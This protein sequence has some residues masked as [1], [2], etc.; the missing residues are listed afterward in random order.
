MPRLEASFRA[1]GLLVLIATYNNASTLKEVIEETAAYTRQ[2]WV[3]NDGSTDET[4]AILSEFP[5]L[6][7]IHFESNQGK[8]AALRAGFQKAYAMGY[9]A[10]ITMDSDGQHKARDLEVF[11][12]AHEMEPEALLLGSRNLYKEHVPSRSQF[13]NRFSN[14]WFYVNTGLRL[15]DTQT[16]Y[17][18]YPLAPLATKRFWGRKF[19]F[20]VEVLV[21]AAWAGVPVLPVPIDVYY[22]HPQERV[23]HF[24]PWQDFGRI[25][26]LNS[27]L[28]MVALFWVH[29]RRLLRSLF[30]PGGW[31]KLRRLIF[32]HPQESNLKKASSL[33]FG[34]FM[35]ILPI[36]GFQLAV[37]I[38]LAILFRLNKMLF[39]LAANISI[40][41]PIIWV[42]SLWLGR[43]LLSL[44]PWTLDWRD[45]RLEEVKQE[46][47]AFLLGGTVLAV[48][49]AG[50]TFLI[51]LL[52]LHFF[53]KPQD[54]ESSDSGE[55]EVEEADE[56]E[57]AEAEQEARQ[58]ASS[59]RT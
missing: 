39:I 30:Q 21:R 37:G 28:V 3:V 33:S 51:S 5:F 41:P 55:D 19:E 56:A 15:P 58:S 25:S 23:S 45:I 24:R 7:V 6:S 8:G 54:L 20:E 52:G 32:V 34:V 18:L 42:A 29:P 10:V 11:L 46:G 1:R 16:G 44:P 48:L 27:V 47:M 35:G 13:G 26:V 53:R 38:P 40:F 36:W 31:K 9:K 14:F 12:E 43:R 59:S 50:L 2:I 57:E 49:A 17:R 4:R 22:P